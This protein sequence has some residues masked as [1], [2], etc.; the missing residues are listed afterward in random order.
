MT[1]KE[2]KDYAKLLYLKENFTQKEIAQKV[3]V[4]EK[5]LSKWV[6]SPGENWERLKASIIVTKEEEL[7]R[8]YM[9][10]NELNTSIFKK[11]EGERFA[12]N[13]ESDTL[14]KLC[15]SARNLETEVS[16]SEV[17]EVSKRVINYLRP[18]DFEK[19]KEMTA[20]FDAFIRDCSRK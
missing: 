13:K 3:D 18:L 9:Q 7:R 15:S 1:L 10:I 11:P 19:A 5:T 14:V 20:I 8:I 16:L 12:S 2:K 4:T 6:N 17:I